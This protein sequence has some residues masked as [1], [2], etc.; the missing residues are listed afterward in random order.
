MT[1]RPEEG[2]GIEPPCLPPP[3]T[4]RRLGHERRLRTERVSGARGR[5]PPLLTAREQRR[6][7]RCVARTGAAE[8]GWNPWSALGSAASAGSRAVTQPRPWRDLDAVTGLRR[9]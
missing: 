6:S 7:P 1:G 3:V 5:A 9:G 2:A 4:A 8:A